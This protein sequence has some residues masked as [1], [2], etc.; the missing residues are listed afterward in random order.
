MTTA[1]ILFEY[2]D[3]FVMAEPLAFELYRRTGRSSF[4]FSAHPG[5]RGLDDR[6]WILPSTH[7]SSGRFALSGAAHEIP[8]PIR[9]MRGCRE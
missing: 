5:H 8:R 6:H 7:G 1:N 2:N 3:R 9:F 4:E